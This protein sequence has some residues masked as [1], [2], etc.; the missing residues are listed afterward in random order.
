MEN[1]TAIDKA[2]LTRIIKELSELSNRLP[3]DEPEEVQM[4]EEDKTPCLFGFDMN[5]SASAEEY[6][7]YYGFLE[8]ITSVLGEFGIH[9]G[10]NGYS[11][12]I[13][14]VKIIIDRKT[15][16]MRLKTDIYPLIATRYRVTNQN[17]VEHSI[18]NAINIAYEDHIRDP[19]CNGMGIFSRRPTNKQFLVYV[20][21]TVTKFMYQSKIRAAS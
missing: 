5:G 21:D 19:Q 16:D 2:M 9:I 7:R 18:R 11:Y 10:N 20:A 12:I 4:A 13:D 8:T 3:D 6:G 1:N 17:A 14:A 15:Y